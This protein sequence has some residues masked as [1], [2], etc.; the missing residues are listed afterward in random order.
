MKNIGTKLK[1]F[2]VLINMT[3]LFGFILNP[4]SVFASEKVN[5]YMFVGEG[6]SHCE[7]LENAFKSIEDE[8]GK[9]YNIKKYEVWYND[10]N[11]E[12]MN[13]T[14]KKLGTEKVRGVPY[15]V[16]GNTSWQGFTDSYLDEMKNKII[17]DYDSNN[18]YDVMNESHSNNKHDVVNESDSNNRS[19]YTWV[20][21]VIVAS[22]YLV[23]VIL[24]KKK[25]V[26]YYKAVAIIGV[27]LLILFINIIAANN[28]QSNNNSD[29]NSIED[30]NDNENSKNNEDNKDNETKPQLYKYDIEKLDYS[31]FKTKFYEI[32]YT[33]T[34]Y[35]G[36][37]LS[38]ESYYTLKEDGTCTYSYI[39]KSLTSSNVMNSTECSY[40]IDGNSFTVKMT[41]NRISKSY[42]ETEKY[43]DSLEITG[44]FSDNFK[45]LKIGK[46]EYSSQHYNTYLERE[47]S[48]VLI[49]PET[50]RDYTLD[51]ESLGNSDYSI[52]VSKYEIIDK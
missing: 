48:Y 1:L 10:D 50:T 11:Y 7:D 14:A 32:H 17:E 6:C 38:G 5:V 3:L 47:M 16:I 4:I 33:G 35:S 45:Y 44:E 43:T 21:L 52:D 31:M 13:K 37:S 15:V 26:K 9:Y 24:L 41:V 34:G 49:D 39:L 22:I 28:E 23:I 27:V 30:N 51:G 29:N 25:N 36:E 8:Y 12:L 42:S 40:T 20:I 19:N 2:V 18:R 46:Y